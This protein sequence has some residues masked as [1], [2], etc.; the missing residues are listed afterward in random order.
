MHIDISKFKNISFKRRTHCMICEQALNEPLIRLPDLP[1]T[2]I[3]TKEKPREKMGFANQDFYLC[4]HCGHGQIANVIDVNLQYG[5]SFS[6]YFRTSQSVTAH[7]STEFFVNFLNKIAGK[8]RFKTIVELGCNDL[9]LLNLI[10]ARGKK[11]IG[12]D[13]ILKGREKEFSHGKVVAVGDFFENA[14]V[15]EP[16]DLVICK[17]T[18][19]HVNDPKAF[20]KKAVDRAAKNAL[21]FFQFPMLETLLEGCRF[22]Q[23][24]HQHLNYFSLRSII[25]MLE[26][27]DC[28]LLDYTVN[29]NLWGSVL[30]AFQ[31]GRRSSKFKKDA[32]MIF[33]HEVLKRYDLFKNNM[34]LTNARLSLLKG[35]KV[36]GYGA[37]LMLPVLSYHLQN[38][39]SALECILD[40][41]TRKRGLYYINLPVE[42]RRR[43][44]VKDFRNAVVLITAI[45]SLNNARRM[46][47]KLFEL[48]PKQIILPLNTI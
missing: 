44:S 15:S 21:F 48:N 11:L 6:Y 26:E 25:H 43:D 17:D 37:A 46:L 36:Y 32:A 10:K 2:E 4:R 35:E 42:I 45:A 34:R 40:D 41:D 30:I 31:K 16:I 33:P 38:D 47:P 27:L 5:S 29:Y 28:E 22:D 18:L 3:Y 7:E 23:I 8:K 24:F 9:Y 20:V 39:F 12:I 13:P 14:A 19:E 1:M